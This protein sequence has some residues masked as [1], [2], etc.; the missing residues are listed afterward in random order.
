MV[1]IDTTVWVHYLRG[2]DTPVGRLVAHLLKANE[3][4]MVGPVLAELLQ[5]AKDEDASAWLRARLERLPFMDLDKRTWTTAGEL[6]LRLR[7]QGRMTPP[8]DLLI[9]ALALQGGHQLYSLDEHLRRVPG[10]R[11]YEAG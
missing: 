10:L 8:M 3:V 1:I 4:L 7:K 2:P 6:S 11:L 9:A 5:G